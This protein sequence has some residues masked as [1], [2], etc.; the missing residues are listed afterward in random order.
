MIYIKFFVVINTF[1]RAIADWISDPI[2]AKSKYGHISDWD[3]SSID[4]M[5]C[6][7]QNRSLF[8][9]DI[10]SWNVRNVKS[11]NNM[12]DG[13]ESF[14]QDISTW[15]IRNAI[16]GLQMNQC[17]SM[18]DNG[19]PISKHFQPILSTSEIPGLLEL[20]NSLFACIFSENNKRIVI[21]EQTINQYYSK[22][23]KFHNY[24]PTK[25]RRSDDDIQQAVDEW[26]S[27]PIYAKEKYGAISQW[28][29]SEVTITLKELFK[30]NIND[31]D[32]FSKWT[33]KCR[34]FDDDIQ[35][36]VD[37]WYRNPIDAK[38]KYGAISH[39]DTSAVTTMDA[40]FQGK[41]KFNDDISKWDVSSVTNMK[42]MFNNTKFDGDISK[43][44]VSSVTSM[45]NMFCN[46]QFDADISGW[47]VSSVRNMEAM[48]MESQFDGDISGWNVSSV[49]NMRSMFSNTPFNG[50]ISGWNV[51]DSCTTNEMFDECPIQEEHK[52]TGRNPEYEI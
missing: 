8:N 51:K 37:E 17:K 41:R 6:A 16:T 12:F 9:D 33:T 18:F 4:K 49:T 24:C 19:C 22:K 14:N 38:V 25:Y 1:I 26:D 10:T 3:V 36:A 31:N 42:S 30:E 39:W 7:F 52:P 45:A 47:D 50:D 15:D 48:F 46:S 13:A 11:F 2:L 21:N 32:N 44:D 20:D 35:Q 40:L 5:D 23:K 27:K 28:D 29:T 43:W 34:R